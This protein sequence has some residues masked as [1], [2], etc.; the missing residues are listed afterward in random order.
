MR[1]RTTSAPGTATATAAGSRLTPTATATTA[2]GYRTIM[3]Y[4][5]IGCCRRVA[6]FSSPTVLVRRS[7]DRF[8]DAG[9]RPCAQPEPV[10]GPFPVDELGRG[11]NR[12]AGWV[13]SCR[14]GCSIRGRGSRRW[15]A[16][17]PVAVGVAGGSVTEVPGVGA[18][19]GAVVG[20]VGGV[21]RGGGVSRCGRVHHGVSVWADTAIGVEPELP[22]ERGGAQCG[23]GQGGRRWQ[24][25]RVHVGADRSGG[26]RQRVRGVA[27]SAVGSLVPARLFDSRPGRGDG[28]RARWPVPVVEVLVR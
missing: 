16:G 7:T 11:T 8:G 22:G 20:V 25:V 3:A 13:R 6:H 18:G 2:A 23:G 4:D 5:A 27:G 21:E 9:Q 26:R 24:G 10:R 15:M 12:G 14:R 19:W 28:R 17:T 1:R